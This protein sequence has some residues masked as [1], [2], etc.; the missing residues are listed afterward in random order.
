MFGNLG[1]CWEGGIRVP[2]VVKWPGR[3]PAGKINMEVGS[4]VDLFPTV[5]ELAGGKIPDDRPYDGINIIPVLEGKNTSERTLF[6][7]RNGTLC[8]VR[9]GKWKLHIRYAAYNR[10]GYGK[11]F[12][13][14]KWITPETPMLFNVEDD[15]SEQYD[16][17]AE[18]PHIAA[19]LTKLA[20]NYKAE[21]QRNAENK[22]LLKWYYNDFDKELEK[23]WKVFN[24]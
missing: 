22:D 24:K 6:F 19:E 17:S 16:V 9:R 12:T 15:S 18:H 20:D 21:I 2:C 4:I 1:D 13:N 7:E 8:A 3:L 14:V 23:Y 5:I 11:K 10:E